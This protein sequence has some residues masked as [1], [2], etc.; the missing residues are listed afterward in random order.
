MDTV[1]EA[2]FFLTIG[3]LAITITVYVLAV[4]LLG[5]AVKLSLEEQEKA[6]N[7]RKADTE[8]TR[9][10]LKGKLDQTTYDRE[11]LEKSLK[12]YKNKIEKHDR[13]LRWIRW[14]PNFLKAN[15]GV[16]IPSCFSL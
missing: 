2:L 1:F 3:L 15:W 4:S 9:S 6:E 14:N 16:F 7:V 5:R 13:T 12:E 10:E 8:R 11:S